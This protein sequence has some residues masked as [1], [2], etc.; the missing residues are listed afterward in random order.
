VAV[1]V[2][3]ARVALNAGTGNQDITTTDLGGETPGAVIFVVTQGVTD[4]TAADHA[5][6]GFGAATA[7]T[8]RWACC[9]TSEH[10][11]AAVDTRRRAMTDECMLK[12]APSGSNVE[13]EADFVAFIADGVRINIAVQGTGTQYLLTALFFEDAS[14]NAFAGTYAPGTSVDASVDVTAPGFEPDLLLL[15]THGIAFG[16]SVNAAFHSMSLGFAVN[17]GADTQRCIAQAEDDPAAAGAPVARLS[18]SHAAMELVETTGA[19]NWASEIDDYDANGFSSIL[20]I[21]TAG[22]ADVGYL[23]LAFGGNDVWVG[24]HASPTAT[25]DDSSTAPGFKPQLVGLGLSFIATE[26]SS[27]TGAAAG[28]FGAGLFTD[29]AEFSNAIAMED[30]SA[31]TDTQSISDNRAVNLPEDDG[32]VGYEG[33][34]ST[35]DTNGWTLNFPTNVDGTTRRWIGFAVQENV[36]AGAFTERGIGRGVIRGVGRGI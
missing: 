11:Q 16:D 27:I 19:I 30:A 9:S 24:S 36:V 14:L 8:E 15:A 10:G 18:T 33:D 25:G 23:A 17:D 12:V 35:F 29:S 4:A 26:D 20:R 2:A 6:I 32:T 3:V 21:A 5:T 31:T 13:I 7:T 28:P 22:T 1:N 34:F